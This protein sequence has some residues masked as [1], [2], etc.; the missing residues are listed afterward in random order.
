MRNATYGGFLQRNSASS[1]RQE[2]FYY[3][4]SNV[5]PEIMVFDNVP[6]HC[7]YATHGCDNSLPA[8]IP[9][10]ET[11]SH[12]L[13]ISADI[14]GSTIPVES[15]LSVTPIVMIIDTATGAYLNSTVA[16]EKSNP[17]AV[18]DITA[19]P[20]AADPAWY[21]LQGIRLDSKPS[22]K[23]IYIHHNK[24]VKIQ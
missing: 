19:D 11:L 21:T 10:K 20:S 8:T 18:T 7:A 14:S 4:P 5:M 17:G 2:Q 1:Y 6:I 16:T 24:L 9:A 13:T 23:G 3:M 12:Q 15:I 22:A